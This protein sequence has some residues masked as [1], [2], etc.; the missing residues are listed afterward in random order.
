M[1]NI[2]A[3]GLLQSP[4]CNRIPYKQ[5]LD[6]RRL[7]LPGLGYTALSYVDSSVK[8]RALWREVSGKL[9]LAQRA[10]PNQSLG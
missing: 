2:L 10:S 5:S 6:L 3:S 4:S 9:L 8:F 1:V 7:K